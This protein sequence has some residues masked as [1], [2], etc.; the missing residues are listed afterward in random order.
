MINIIRDKEGNIQLSG[1]IK[2]NGSL[3]EMEQEILEV[4]N[5]IGNELTVEAIKQFDTDGSPI[6]KDG[7]KLTARSKNVKAYQTPYGVAK[8]I[9]ISKLKGREDILPIRRVCSNNI[10]SNSQICSANIT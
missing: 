7:V 6:I 5:E 3:M 10:Y 9:C 1:S 2:L 4:V 8:A